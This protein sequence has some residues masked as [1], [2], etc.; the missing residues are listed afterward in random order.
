MKNRKRTNRILALLLSLCVLLTMAPAAVFAADGTV[1]YIGDAGYDSLGSAVRAASSGATIT[2]KEDD[3]TA[4]TITISKNLTIELDGHDLTNT[5]FNITGGNVVIRDRQGIAT[6][7]CEEDQAIQADFNYSAYATIYSAGGSLTLEGVNVN[8]Y[9]GSN[10]RLPKAVVIEGSSVTINSGSFKGGDA[11][12]SGGD[13][14]YFHEG[15]LTINGGTF[16]GGDGGGCGLSSTNRPGDSL[17]IRNGTFIGGGSNSAAFWLGTSI[18]SEASLKEYFLSE[19]NYIVGTFD[20]TNVTIGSNLFLSS[21]YT[22]PENGSGDVNAPAIIELPADDSVTLD[23]HVLGGEGGNLTYEWYKDNEKI[24]NASGSTY[25]VNGEGDYTGHYHAVISESGTEHTITVYWQVVEGY[26]TYNVW[27]GGVQVTEKNASDVLGDED[28][29]GATVSYAAE[30]KTLTLNGAT[31]TATH[32]VPGGGDAAIVSYDDLNIVLAED[33]ENKITLTSSDILT[34][35]IAISEDGGGNDVKNIAVSGSGSLDINITTSSGA[36]FGIMG[37]AVTINGAEVGVTANMTSI[38]DMTSYIGIVGYSSVAIEKGS[39]VTATVSNGAA[40]NIAVMSAGALTIDNANVTA[41]GYA[42]IM[43]MGDI[44]IT[45]ESTVKATG[46]AYAIAATATRDITLDETLIAQGRADA[47]VGELLEVEVDSVIDGNTS[48]T[49]KTF[50][51]S[52]NTST[53]AHYVEIV[54][55]SSLHSHAI[56]GET[57]CAHDG[58]EPVIYTAL[59][60]GA[61]N[62]ADGITTPG[63]YYSNVLN[64]GNYYLTDDITDV[65]LS[66]EITGTVNLCLN[67]H[68]ISGSAAYGIFRIGAGGVLNIC[69][70]QQGGKIT[71]TGEDEHNPI[72][73]HDSNVADVITSFQ[74]RTELFLETLP[75]PFFYSLILTDTLVQKLIRILAF[76]NN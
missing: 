15:N 49:F 35:V 42:G 71:E 47:A 19:E 2:L 41:S 44:S 67:G 33:S 9:E 56:C 61:G 40:G 66:I 8:G 63:G 60:D 64:P 6:I 45:G 5:S 23:P 21:V 18:S 75:V 74:Y 54:P 59:D 48:N 34:G 14:V 1:A 72:F 11:G 27:V 4:Q 31:I 10:Y 12:N 22:E 37:S 29:E 51:L 13:A 68:T 38:G 69:D 76:C 70:C 58:H 43:G 17:S 28:G 46:S 20:R 30:T 24:D 36:A 26:E 3:T 62:L 32:N 39:A 73:L 25:T 16:T 7:S 57:D 52:S 65:T 53:V 50:V 55:A